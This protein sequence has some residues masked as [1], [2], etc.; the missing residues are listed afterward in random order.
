MIGIEIVDN[1]VYA[2]NYPGARRGDEMDDGRIPRHTL[3]FK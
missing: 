2:K 1:V 3:M